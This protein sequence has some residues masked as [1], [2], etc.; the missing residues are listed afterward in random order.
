MLENTEM[1]N[2]FETFDKMMRDKERQGRQDKSLI[3][4]LEQDMRVIKGEKREL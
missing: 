2:Q 3:E 1:Q 4:R